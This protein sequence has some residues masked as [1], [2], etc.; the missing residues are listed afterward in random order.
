MAQDLP[1]HEIEHS[2]EEEGAHNTASLEIARQHSAHVNRPLTQREQR[3][4]AGLGWVIRQ[5]DSDGGE[6]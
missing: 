4:R 2:R 1:E 6:G 5:E 3:E